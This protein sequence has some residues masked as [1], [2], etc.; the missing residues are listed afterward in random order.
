MFY[1]G[2][3]YVAHTKCITENERYGGKGY[4][5]KPGQNKGER[6]QQAWI[7]VVQNVLTNSTTLTVP[8][9]NLLSSISKHE[10][11]PRKKAKFLNFIKNISGNRVN[12]NI[13]ESVWV[14]METAFKEAS[15]QI[16]KEGQNNAKR[17]L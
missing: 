2:D 15:A 13:V 11:I 7:N 8:E 6:K 1:R 3:E 4:V 17:K 14:K 10:N 9:R 5:A 16:D 12:M